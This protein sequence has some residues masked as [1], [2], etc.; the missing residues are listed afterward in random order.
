VARVA[1]V[2][3]VRVAGAPLVLVVGLAAAVTRRAR[4]HREVAGVRVALRAV[5]LA[6]RSGGDGEPRVREPPLAPGR[7]GRTV[8]DLA[9]HGKSGGAVAGAGRALVVGAMTALTIAGRAVEDVVHVTDAADLLGVLAEQTKHAVVIERAIAPARGVRPVTTGAIGAQAG[10]G[11]IG[12]GRALI[13]VA[14]TPDAIAR[15]AAVDAVDVARRALLLRVL[16]DEREHA[17]V[18]ETLTA[19]E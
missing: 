16:A 14:M 5:A 4:E 10:R 2:R 1:P 15:G 19:P 6:V 18:I 3:V 11:V 17:A 8:A 7:V 9:G 13:V 12:C